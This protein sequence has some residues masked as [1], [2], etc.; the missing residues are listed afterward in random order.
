[1]KP[2]QI[3]QTAWYALQATLQLAVAYPS[4]HIPC[5]RLAHAGRMPERFLLQILRTLVVRGVLRSVRGSD[6]GYAL[7]RP[8]SEISLLHILEAVEGP[9]HTAAHADG[10]QSDPLHLL[11]RETCEAITDHAR[12]R[13][14]DLKLSDCLATRSVAGGCTTLTS[15]NKLFPP[16]T[17]LQPVSTQATKTRR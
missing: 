7:A 13:L 10:W 14:G 6:G 5:G 15:E 8:P 2:L 12:S 16:Q 9:I 11:L 17:R 1:M 4:H 3:S